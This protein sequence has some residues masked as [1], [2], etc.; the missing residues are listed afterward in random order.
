MVLSPDTN[1]RVLNQPLPGEILSNG[2]G[3]CLFVKG[4]YSSIDGDYA[5]E[6]IEEGGP[7]S[8]ERIYYS[9]VGQNWLGIG[10]KAYDFRNYRFAISPTRK[11]YPPYNV[12]N[13]TITNGTARPYRGDKSVY[14]SL[15]DVLI[16]IKDATADR[17]YYQKFVLS[18]SELVSD[19]EPQ[20]VEIPVGT[21]Q[22][23]LRSATVNGVFSGAD[24]VDG[25]IYGIWASSGSTQ[26]TAPENTE[27]FEWYDVN[28]HKITYR[29]DNGVFV[30]DDDFWYAYGAGI[31]AARYVVSNKI[32]GGVTI[33]CKP[34]IDKT[35]NPI[36]HVDYSD[37]DFHLLRVHAIFKKG[38]FGAYV[39]NLLT[40]EEP[41]PDSD[42]PDSDSDTDPV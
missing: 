14:T 17:L 20:Y 41:D 28:E 35:G 32:S 15:M 13:Y 8:R 37:Y 22:T 21:N 12:T 30:S 11:T 34:K 5:V 26:S 3:H 31:N 38:V 19:G 42:D 36:E 7:F 6:T 1:V 2:Y 16:N 39:C 24:L 25:G 10:D 23:V 40:G 18:D 29:I 9:G 27:Y 4:I 33:G